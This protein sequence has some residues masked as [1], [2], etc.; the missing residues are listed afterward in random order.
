M[1]NRGS[2]SG[3]GGSPVHERRQSDRVSVSSS[4]SLVQVT[5]GMM[6][7]GRLEGGAGGDTALLWKRRK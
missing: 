5:C 6:P 1:T 2:W 3:G 7:S 4:L